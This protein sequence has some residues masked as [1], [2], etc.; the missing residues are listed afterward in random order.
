MSAPLVEFRDPADLPECSYS[1]H[2]METMEP[3]EQ[4][5]GTTHYIAELL[6]DALLHLAGDQEREAGDLVA[7]GRR[8]V[9]LLAQLAPHRIPALDPRCTAYQTSG[10][11][12]ASLAEASSPLWEWLADASP[13][14]F[15]AFGMRALVLLYVVRNDLIGGMT[16]E[17]IGELDNST[18][19]AVDKLVTNLRDTLG[20]A[21]R[22]R[23]MKSE[24]TRTR[25]RNAH[26]T[27]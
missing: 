27:K 26:F 25:C 3:V 10:D 19:Q 6:R 4:A 1:A 22:S 24:N 8:A 12:A 13:A 14:R 5:S 20:G 16:L 9:A 7:Y 23:V 2:P 11:D 21:A 18:R 15:S 17:Q